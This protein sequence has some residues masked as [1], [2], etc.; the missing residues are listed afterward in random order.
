LA[1]ATAT[2]IHFRGAGKFYITGFNV[3]LLDLPLYK[4]YL[5]QMVKM[6]PL[7]SYSIEVVEDDHLTRVLGT[8]VAAEQA[9]AR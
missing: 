3:R 5:H 2:S 1:A 8:A 6:S 4:D 7:Q 9:A